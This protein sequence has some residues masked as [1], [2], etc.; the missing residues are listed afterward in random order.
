MG[1]QSKQETAVRWAEES[2]DRG[3]CKSDTQRENA[4]VPWEEEEGAEASLGVFPS[5]P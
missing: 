4:R 2:H 5:L 3:T 1:K